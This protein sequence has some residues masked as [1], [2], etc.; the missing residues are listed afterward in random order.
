[1]IDLCLRH[2]MGADLLTVLKVLIVKIH[3]TK[4]AWTLGAGSEIVKGLPSSP[5]QYLRNRSLSI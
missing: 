4:S 2:L 3:R 1:M 5:C